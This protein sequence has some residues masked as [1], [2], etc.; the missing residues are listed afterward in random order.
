MF[1]LICQYKKIYNILSFKNNKKMLIFNREYIR[2]ERLFL[3]RVYKKSHFK[4][5]YDFI[6]NLWTRFYKKKMETILYDI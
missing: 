6:F 5:I 4:G 1:N 2:V 3:A